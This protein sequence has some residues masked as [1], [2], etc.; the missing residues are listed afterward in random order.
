MVHERLRVPFFFCTFAEKFSKCNT[1]ND[2]ESII[3]KVLD[4]VVEESTLTINEDVTILPEDIIGK[5]KRDNVKMARCIFVA[6]MKCLG[7]SNATIAA[8]LH[9]QQKAIPEILS[10]AYE[11]KKSSRLFR[12]TDAKCTIRVNEIVPE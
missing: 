12:L 8:F 6:Q 5:C 10:A 11:Y 2:K 9:R 4:I 1:M 7:Y 3:Y